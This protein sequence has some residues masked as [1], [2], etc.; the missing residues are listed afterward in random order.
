[1]LFSVY[2][3]S[4]YQDCIWCNVLAMDV[5]HYLLERSWLYDLDV[6]SFDKFNTY[7]FICNGKR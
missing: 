6:I 3:V 2:P 4:S 7:T 5:V 1:M